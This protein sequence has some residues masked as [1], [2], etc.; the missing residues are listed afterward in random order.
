MSRAM[1][2]VSVTHA[3]NGLAIRTADMLR[4][5]IGEQR[6]PWSVCVTTP[7]DDARW[8]V[9]VFGSSGGDPFKWELSVRGRE[10]SPEAIARRFCFD[11]NRPI[12][13]DLRTWYRA[14]T[15]ETFDSVQRAIAWARSAVVSGERTN[16]FLHECPAGA[17]CRVYRSGQETLVESSSALHASEPIRPDAALVSASFRPR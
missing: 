9:Q 8:L 2:E 5:V 15:G 16:V 7:Q 12:P 14:D 3:E 10:K 17:R 4:A 1:T 13:V 6:G 11:T